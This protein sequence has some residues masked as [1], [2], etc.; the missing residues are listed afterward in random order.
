MSLKQE[1][2]VLDYFGPLCV[3]AAFFIVVFIISITCL[4]YCCVS[5]AD[6]MTMMRKWRKPK[7]T[8]RYDVTDEQKAS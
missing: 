4:L 8:R 3:F 5:D 6:D 2:E 1:L 7:Q